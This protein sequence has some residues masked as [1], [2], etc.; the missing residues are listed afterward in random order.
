MRLTSISLIALLALSANAQT[1][2]PKQ[3]GTPVQ[4]QPAKTIAP[5]K[6]AAP[7]AKAITAKPVA[8]KTATTTKPAAK[9]PMAR[10]ATA[11]AAPV[12]AK[13]AAKP[14]AK[15]AA[16]PVARMAPPAA[17]PT[18]VKVPEIARANR[19]DPFISPVR[20]AEERMRNNPACT[21]GARCLVINQLVLKGTVKTQN[22]MIAMVENAAKKQYNLHE[23]DTVQNGSV[24][25]I[26]P[27]SIVFQ[28]SATDP[29]GRAVTKEV[30]KRVTVPA[31]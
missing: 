10:P 22:G 24:V 14:V 21:T 2:K 28:E 25:K 30:V 27:D 15:P 5:A 11:K 19:R 3:A 8:Q 17:K 12:P 4:K 18:P 7:A 23:K 1:P 29:L 20:L 26:T 9:V 6:T 16:K 13:T 31:V